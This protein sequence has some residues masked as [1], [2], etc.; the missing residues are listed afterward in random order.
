MK[1]IIN[2]AEFTKKIEIAKNA[3]LNFEIEIFSYGVQYKTRRESINRT[4]I[5]IS[6]K[7]LNIK[8][9]TFID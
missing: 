7:K 6:G 4:I 2:E 9:T 8:K 3:T 1:L 5:I